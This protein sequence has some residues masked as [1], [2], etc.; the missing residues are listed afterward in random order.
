MLNRIAESFY[1]IGRYM[2]RVDFTA[3]LLDINYHS[4]HVLL[5]NEHNLEYFK[6]RVI[7]S[8][9]DHPF[10]EQL[11]A[12]H[13]N[14]FLHYIIFEDTYKNSILSCLGKA[15]HNIRIVR[16]QIPEKIWDS[17]NSFYLWLKEQNV[18]K[19]RKQLPYSFFEKILQHVSIFNG[20]TDLT[21]LRGNEW[22]FIQAGRYME[23]A[24]N[25][26]RTLQ[27]SFEQNK[28]ETELGQKRDEFNQFASILES[29]DGLEAF[30]RYHADEIKADH[31][32]EFLVLNKAFPS[33]LS[34][35][36]TNLEMFL[37]IIQN[38]FYTVRYTKLNRL[39]TDMKVNLSANLHIEAKSSSDYPSLLKGLQG[40]VN[41]I[42][43]EIE[44]CFFYGGGEEFSESSLQKKVAVL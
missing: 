25:T 31:L 9:G 42:G 1:W 37:K 43:A 16:G 35:S 7:G 27:L 36:F 8:L 21:M 17:I 30:R 24:G 41:E 13:Y 32:I 11:S 3:R 40:M 34:F 23:R 28:V 26:V 29:V 39:M 44:Y 14:D 4:Q 10:T 2:E 33:S 38:D 18:Q 19:G 20:I 12:I 5:E 15:R 6:N 22:N